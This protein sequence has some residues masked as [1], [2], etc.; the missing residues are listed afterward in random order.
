[1]STSD[2]MARFLARQLHRIQVSLRTPAHAPGHRKPALDELAEQDEP[3]DV[4][5]GGWQVIDTDADAER[6]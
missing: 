2:D 6:S 4:L 1:M 3:N 5:D